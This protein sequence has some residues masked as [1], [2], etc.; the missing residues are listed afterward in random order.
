MFRYKLEISPLSAQG[1]ESLPPEKR[2]M[3]TGMLALLAQA[4]KAMPEVTSTAVNQDNSITIESNQDLDLRFRS[5][6]NQ[7]KVSKLS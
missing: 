7:V 6:G 3:L 5:L 4:F 2:Q 1:A